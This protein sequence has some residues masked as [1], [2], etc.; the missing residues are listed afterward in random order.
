MKK[1]L[2]ATIG[3]PAHNE[4]ANIGILLNSIMS[5]KIDRN[6]TLQKIIV[7][8]DGC[9]DKTAQVVRDYSKKDSR[10][11]VQNDGQRI[12]QIGRLNKLYK[13]VK[14]DVFIT[15]DADTTLGND[16]VVS[17]ILRCF[18]DPQVM[19]VG[20]NDTPLAGTTLISR[21]GVTWVSAWYQMRSRINNGD[22]VHNHKGCASA[23]RT[24]FLRTISIPPEV[25]AND[26]FLYFSNLTNGYKFKFAE[27][28]IVYY[29]IPSNLNEYI[30]QTTRF[31]SSH[32]KIANQFGQWV[33]GYY[34]VPVI[35]KINGI[36]ITFLRH[37]ILVSLGIF[38]QVWQRLAKS[39]YGHNSKSV[40]WQEIR[41]SK[42]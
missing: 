1:V 38:L 40:F 35:N 18:N 12:G 31:I 29:K 42:L 30:T 34:Q 14:E 16:M 19:L 9:T 36:F 11:I 13:T 37:P 17:E 6:Y 32:E 39:Y 23:A 24:T 20:G 2:T 41:S 25:I 4:E 33:Y 28:A 7:S 15:F 5:Q 21:I 22:T 3:I 10:I 8:C 26:D 27:K